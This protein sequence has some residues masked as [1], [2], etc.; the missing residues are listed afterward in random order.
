MEGGG[1]PEMQHFMTC[2]FS[3]PSDSLAFSGSVP[4]NQVPK[5]DPSS[6]LVTWC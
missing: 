2:V 3:V 5:H 6:L 4:I 1:Q